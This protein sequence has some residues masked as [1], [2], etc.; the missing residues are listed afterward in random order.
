M[1]LGPLA[2]AATVLAAA[3][4]QEQTSTLDDVHTWF[5][6]IAAGLTALALVIGASWAYFKF[7]KGRT[8][9]PRLDVGMVG[10]WHVVDRKPL[11][12]ARVTVTN[13]G[14]SVVRPLEKGSGLRVS[15]LAEDQ[16]PAP[17]AEVWHAL[18]VFNVLTDDHKWIEPQETVSDDLLLDL[19]LSRPV[20]ALFEARFVW[21]RRWPRRNTVILARQV[22]PVDS[23]IDAKASASGR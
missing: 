6:I 20:V 16:P 12:Q 10:Q 14:A 23:T 13:V 17:S 8:F 5:D 11:L 2:S 3:D 22:V 19:G 18:R 1:M 15:V 7:V 21:R 4:N 9:R